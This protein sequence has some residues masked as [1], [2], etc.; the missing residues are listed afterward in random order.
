MDLASSSANKAGSNTDENILKYSGVSLD[1]IVYE[2]Q[3]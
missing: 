1:I 3:E 2:F